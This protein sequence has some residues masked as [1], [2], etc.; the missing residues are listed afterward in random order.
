MV[1]ES[2]IVEEITEL[3]DLEPV[4]ITIISEILDDLVEFISDTTVRVVATSILYA[5]LQEGIYTAFPRT[6]TRFVIIP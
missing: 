1:Q 4:D 5:E 3:E 2:V 6:V